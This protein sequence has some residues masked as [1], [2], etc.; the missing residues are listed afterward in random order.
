M[1]TFVTLPDYQGA[2]IGNALSNF[3]T[4]L[5]K[6]LGYR[7]L[8]TTTHPAMIAAR[9]RRGLW[10]LTRRPSFALGGDRLVHATTRLTA[11]FEYIGPP[12]RAA[13]GKGLL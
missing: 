6:G 2:G 4:S 13:L 1:S 5:W 10:R 11:G 8:S 9:Q 7:A 12:L 3:V